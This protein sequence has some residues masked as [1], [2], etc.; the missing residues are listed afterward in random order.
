LLKE[1]IYTVE[2]LTLSIKKDLETKFIDIWV[3]GEL[4]DIKESQLGHIYFI[5]RDKNSQLNC[6]LFE[7]RAIVLKDR[8]KEGFQVIVRGDISV[9]QRRGE[10]RL[11]VNYVEYLTEG[12]LALEFVRLKTKLK[13]QGIFDKPKKQLP[14]LIKRVGIITSPNAAA[15]SDVLKIFNQY[16]PNLEILIYPVTVQGDSAADEI[17]EAIM[18]FNNKK[19]ITQEVDLILLCRGGGSLQDLWAFNE[20]AVAYAIYN[21]N[22]PVISAIGHESDYVITDFVSDI[23]APTPTAAAELICKHITKTYQLIQDYKDYL[24]KEINQ[25][26]SICFE[27]LSYYNKTLE[28]LNPLRKINLFHQTL[29]ELYNELTKN[30]TNLL[31]LKMIKLK[32]LQEKINHLNPVNILKRGYSITFKLPENKILKSKSWVISG[33]DIKIKLSDGEIFAQVI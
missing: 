16:K 32:F 8:L 9:Y 29:D 28:L 27:R 25:K 23:R 3:K 11:I 24:T 20:E 26:F 31:K 2:E 30:I 18:D 21:S 22:I 14:S 7:E 13:N 33:D 10:Y 6:V 1:K 5:L 12:E 17:K 4:C 19:K 15:L